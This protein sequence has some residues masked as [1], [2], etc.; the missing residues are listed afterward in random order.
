VVVTPSADLTAFTRGVW[1]SENGTVL[2]LL[3]TAPSGARGLGV[4]TIDLRLA[5]EGAF[6]SPVVDRCAAVTSVTGKERLMR[7][8]AKPAK[9]KYSDPQLR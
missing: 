2:D 1:A 7:Q 3:K 4:L 6:A 8:R 9:A 5:H